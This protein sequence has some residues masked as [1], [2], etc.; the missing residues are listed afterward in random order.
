MIDERVE[1]I[2]DAQEVAFDQWF[3]EWF[4]YARNFMKDEFKNLKPW[5]FPKIKKAYKEKE[6]PIEVTFEDIEF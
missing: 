5:D 6:E 2:W 4:D 1:M 3:G